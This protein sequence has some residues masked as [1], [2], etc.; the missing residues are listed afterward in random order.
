MALI[1]SQMGFVMPV[2]HGDAG[3]A[4]MAGRPKNPDHALRAGGST[5]RRPSGRGI[6]KCNR[7]L[8]P[9]KVFDTL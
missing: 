1:Y 3:Q 7:W 5:S 4:P 2:H 6:S 9:F 8:A